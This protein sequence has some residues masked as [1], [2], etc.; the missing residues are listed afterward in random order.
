MTESD[1]D[2][3]LV[4]AALDI[5]TFQS[6]VARLEK[7]V[8]RK[9]GDRKAEF[10]AAIRAGRKLIADMDV[11][12]LVTPARLKRSQT[13]LRTY[14]PKS[15]KLDD[16]VGAHVHHVLKACGGNKKQAAERLGVSRATL[17]RML[18]WAKPDQEA[19]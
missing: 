11:R 10:L 4:R 15:L 14:M 9:S 8:G 6:R 7:E 19:A 18:D 2:A 1:K 17:Y 5:M 12:E 13:D 16:I 3:L